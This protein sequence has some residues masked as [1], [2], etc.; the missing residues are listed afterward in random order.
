[1]TTF[2]KRHELR[3]AKRRLHQRGMAK[4]MQ[5]AGGYNSFKWR[6]VVDRVRIKVVRRVQFAQARKEAKI[7][8]A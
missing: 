5:K 8:N 1:M 4:L 6:M 3:K 2:E 7:A